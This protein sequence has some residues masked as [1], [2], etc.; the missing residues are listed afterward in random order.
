MENA[1]VCRV[2]DH[3]RGGE[4][5][6][7]FLMF[8]EAV[9]RLENRGVSEFAVDLEDL[10]V[11]FD[12]RAAVDADR[13]V[14]AVHHPATAAAETAQTGGIEIERIKETGAGRAGNAIVL[15]APPP[16]LKLFP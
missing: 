2:V 4:L 10:P 15:N 9:A 14:D 16:P 1:R 5:K 11:E 8:F 3:G 7:K 13:A 6:P 12:P